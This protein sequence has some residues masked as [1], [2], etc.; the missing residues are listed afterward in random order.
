MPPGGSGGTSSGALLAMPM[1]VMNMG[2]EM[3]YILEQRLHAQSIPV[4]KSRKG[5]AHAG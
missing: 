1:L 3:V 5:E 4:E 2:G